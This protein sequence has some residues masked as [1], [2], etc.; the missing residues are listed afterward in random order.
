[1][2]KESRNVLSKY[3]TITEQESD[4]VVMEVD[5]AELTKAP[6]AEDMAA[7]HD[8]EMMETPVIKQD[9]YLPSRFKTQGQLLEERPESLSL[10]KEKFDPESIE[11]INKYFKYK[12][13][14][15]LQESLVSFNQQMLKNDK[16]VKRGNK[17]E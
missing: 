17:Y 15:E 2:K 11:L 6:G 9:V 7:A 14:N 4:V 16:V 8:K 10:I 3:A 12:K 1:M 5:G 13:F